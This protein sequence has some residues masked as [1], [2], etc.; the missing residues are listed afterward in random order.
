MKLCNVST[1]FQSTKKERFNREFLTSTYFSVALQSNTMSLFLF[2]SIFFL[3]FT[4]YYLIFFSSRYGMTV[5]VF[6]F[7]YLASNNISIFFANT[8]WSRTICSPFS[9]IFHRLIECGLNNWGHRQLSSFFKYIIETLRTVYCHYTLTTI[10]FIIK[11]YSLLI[12]W[13]RM[14]I[15]IN[16]IKLFY[17]LVLFCQILH[18]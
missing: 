6:F 15:S 14:F 5:C 17:A 1:A 16:I 10:P 2:N 8:K 18:P 9:R 13:I 3:S 12:T 4:Y 11:K 7:N